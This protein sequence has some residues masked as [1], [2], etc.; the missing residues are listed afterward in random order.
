MG[1][2][3]IVGSSLTA[4]RRAALAARIEATPWQFVGQEPPQFSTAPTDHY[5]GGLTAANVGLRLFTVSQRSGYAPMI[6]GLGYV[7]APGTDAYTLKTVA[8]KDVWVQPLTRA[9]AE[10][11]VPLAVLE[12][13][14]GTGSGTGGISSPRVLSD[15][16]W[17]GRY[18]ERAE[19]MARLLNITRERYHEYRHRQ[20]L[21]AS[22]CVP[23]LL[24]ALGELTGT[25]TAA[26]DDHAETIAVAPTTLWSLTADRTR[27]GSLAQSVERLGLTARAVRDQMSNDTWM[28]LAAVDRAVLNQPARP[29]DS[30]V[31]A[32]A[33][34]ASAHARTLAG[35]LALAGV[36]AES[37]VRDVGWTTM[38][39]GKR[40]ERGLWLSALLRSATTSVRSADAEQAII[41]AILVACES[42]VIYR[43]R[44]LGKVS[45]AAVADLLLFDAENPRSL[46]FQLERLRANLRAMPGASGSSKPE[47]LLEEMMIRVRRLDPDD[48]EDVDEDGR[49]A[50]LAG[51]LD[52]VHS[53]LRELST[54]ITETQLS[55]PGGM[56]PLW[57]PDQRRSLP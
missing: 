40:I 27:S 39:S 57:G 32:D 47:R 11:A 14:T 56:Q 41:E 10:R 5:N 31:R 42:S 6:G 52:G 46:V 28:V 50:E 2:P 49:R 51:L 45:I 13:P 38:D 25:D 53:G 54:V 12:L 35:M 37:M 9:A 1:A 22:E 30:L 3:P 7:L 4:E 20:Y 18:A 21:D 17:T 26:A 29:P 44:N 19:N 8:A 34:M 55:L 16:F 15:L 36:A 33:Q 23:V 24:S 43:R 48:L